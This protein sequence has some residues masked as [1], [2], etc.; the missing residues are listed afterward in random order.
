MNPN[1]VIVAL[2]IGATLC[3]GCSKEDREN[4]IDRA[5]KAGKA[6]NGEVV[7][8]TKER[9]I[10]TIVE[11][12]QKKERVRQNTQWT[13]ENQRLHPQEYC[14]AQLEETGK[15]SKKLD[16][17]Q[18]KL[19]MSKSSLSRK[20]S[21][22]ELQRK[23]LSDFLSKAKVAYKDAEANNSFP[24]T[25]NGYPV[26]K[27]KAQQA[28]IEANRKLKIAQEQI[29]PTRNSLATAEKKLKQIAEEQRKIV[30]LREKLQSTLSDLQMK[31]VIEGENGIGDALKAIDDSMNAL[32]TASNEPDVLDIMV[33]DEKT[34]QQ[35][36]FDAIMKE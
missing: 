7:D 25:L 16:V 9:A 5:A 20:V 30:A 12:Q 36:E 31:Q 1:T 17:Q 15:M 13:A 14:Q 21:D 34:Q 24:I 29:V 22:L 19:L 11:E 18:H 26:S 2:T 6:L 32:Q 8:N 33:P 3:A 4:I 23:Q 10:P 35:S 28:I 27:E